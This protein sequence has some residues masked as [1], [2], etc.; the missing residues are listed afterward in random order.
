[1]VILDFD[2]GFFKEFGTLLRRRAPKKFNLLKWIY[3]GHEIQRGLPCIPSFRRGPPQI[4]RIT[5][6]APRETSQHG[7]G[8]L[9]YFKK[10]C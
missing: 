5:H 9:I 1:M 7:P 10:G 4:L 3:E 6:D 8:I 2:N